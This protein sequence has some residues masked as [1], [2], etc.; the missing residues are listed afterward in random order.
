MLNLNKNLIQLNIVQNNKIISSF[1]N[2]LNYKQINWNYNYTTDEKECIFPNFYM[3]VLHLRPTGK[4]QYWGALAKIIFLHKLTLSLVAHQ[5][6]LRKNLFFNLSNLK[7]KDIK[8]KKNPSKQDVTNDFST[9]NRT[10]H[11][12]PRL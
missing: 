10:T 8:G 11:V 7:I 4:T 1:F 6:F 12:D 5:A 3:K 9:S 2:T